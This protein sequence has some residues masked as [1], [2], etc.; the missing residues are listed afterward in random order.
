VVNV[1][2]VPGPALYGFV[3]P[4]L[5]QQIHRKQPSP[6]TERHPP[7]HTEHHKDGTEEEQEP[8]HQSIQRP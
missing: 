7:I 6:D 3:L 4:V 1:R 5:N 2:L 8:A